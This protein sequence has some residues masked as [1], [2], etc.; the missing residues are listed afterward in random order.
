MFDYNTGVMTDANFGSITGVRP[1]SNRI[2]QLG[3]RFR[4]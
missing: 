4:F 3:L 2:I 1:N